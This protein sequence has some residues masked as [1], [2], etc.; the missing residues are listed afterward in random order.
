MTYSAQRDYCQ[1]PAY[2]SNRNDKDITMKMIITHK[3]NIT[4]YKVK[5][6]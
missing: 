4:Y 1:T 5:Y 2:S 6:Q 3:V